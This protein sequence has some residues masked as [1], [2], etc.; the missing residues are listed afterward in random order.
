MEINSLDMLNIRTMQFTFILLLTSSVYHWLLC[1]L[2]SLIT[3]YL[4]RYFPSSSRQYCRPNQ[5][6]SIVVSV[7][8]LLLSHC[9]FISPRRYYS[10]S[11]L[12]VCSFVGVFVTVFVSYFAY[13]H[14]LQ[15]QAGYVPGRQPCSCLAEMVPVLVS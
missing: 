5:L 9:I 12:L 14:R 7:T 13:G 11:C 10:P 2:C 3:S 4:E 1:C 15:W 6:P 8:V